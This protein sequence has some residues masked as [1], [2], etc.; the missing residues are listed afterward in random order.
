MAEID[1]SWIKPGI[2]VVVLATG[3]RANPRRM[4][5]GKVAAQ[6]FTLDGLDERIK[7]DRLESKRL[8]GTWNTWRYRV[9]KPD[10][11]E[12]LRAFECER[13]GRLNGLAHAAAKDWLIGGGSD[14]PDKVDAVIAAFQ[15]YRS[16]LGIQEGGSEVSDVD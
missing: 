6:S 4:K 2:E 16:A 1:S 10:S 9:V 11:V 12:A 15:A 14:N 8:G 7:L 13:V 3:G 5:V